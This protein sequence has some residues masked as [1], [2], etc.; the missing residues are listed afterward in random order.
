[1]TD[2]RWPR[3]NAWLVAVIALAAGLVAL[4]TWTLVD[5]PTTSEPAAVQIVDDLNAAVN[6]GDAEAVRALFAPGAVFQVSTGDQIA[7]LDNVVNT[8][9]IPHAVGFRIE[10]VAPVTTEGNA[11]A[12]FIKYGNG[13]EGI[14]LVV[15]RFKDGKIVRQWVYDE[16]YR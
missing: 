15:F 3:I 16:G 7:G 12:T 8:A 9:L 6:A 13:S 11:A 14:E 1:L 4:S 2:L 5:R 10:R